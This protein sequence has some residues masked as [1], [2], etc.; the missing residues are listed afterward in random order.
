MSII[1]QVS[2][3]SAMLDVHMLRA[4]LHHTK[5]YFHHPLCTRIINFQRKTVSFSPLLL[6][7]IFLKRGHHFQS[8]CIIL[9]RHGGTH[10]QT[11][12][13]TVLLSFHFFSELWFLRGWG[14]AYIFLVVIWAG[15][16]AR[17]QMQS[18]FNKEMCSFRMCSLLF[19]LLLNNNF[20]G[21]KRP[22]WFTLSFL[23]VAS[24][25]RLVGLWVTFFRGCAIM[26]IIVTGV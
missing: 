15:K 8:P 3:F 2:W 25:V 5:V 20:W 1:P 26:W 16:L 19:S 9:K 21:D 12:W 4:V 24:A 17:S 6:M 7:L 23:G 14:T 13:L 22:I 18:V 11:G 10:N